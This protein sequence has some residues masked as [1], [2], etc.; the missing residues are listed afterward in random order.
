MS[1]AMIS[2]TAYASKGASSCS[3]FSSGSAAGTA[4]RKPRV[5]PNA[6][7]VRRDGMPPRR[8]GV[9]SIEDCM[10]NENTPPTR[11]TKIFSMRQPRTTI[12][13]GTTAPR[14]HGAT[15]HH[16][17]SRPYGIEAATADGS[18]RVGHRGEGLKAR[19]PS[20]RIHDPG[21]VYFV[22][23]Q[24]F[25]TTSRLRAET[26]RSI[27]FQGLHEVEVKSRQTHAC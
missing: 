19:V 13:H 8:L 27:Y 17:I 16:L 14:H 1:T 5:T 15:A 11:G 20:M 4:P 24:L 23:F 7:C 2:R 25:F 3:T 22:P 21:I 18:G 6:R 10:Q 9:T 12:R 26:Q